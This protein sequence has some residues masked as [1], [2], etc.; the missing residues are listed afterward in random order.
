MAS[1]TNR[2]RAVVGRRRFLQFAGASGAVALA[3]CADLIQSDNGDGGGGG[4]S[5]RHV[6]NTNTVPKDIQWNTSNPSNRAQISN[7]ALFDPFVRY[8]FATSEFTPYAISDW[9][10]GGDTFEMTVRDG[11]TWSNGDDVTS[12][13]V[14]TQLRIGMKTGATYA[15]YTNAIETPDE[16][17]VSLQF[18]SKINQKIVEF[19]ILAER[20]VHQKESEFG[21][22]LE[23]INENEDEGLKQLQEFAY[24]EPIASGPFEYDSADQQQLL[25]TLRE[26]HPDSGK[27]NFGEYVFKYHDGNQAIHQALKNNDIDS[28]FTVFTPTETVNSLPDNIKQ[29]QTPSNWGYGLVPNHNHKHLGDRAVRKAIQFVIN[30]KQVVGNVSPD[31]K[32]VPPYPMGISSGGQE[33]WLGDAIENFESYGPD[34]SQTKKAA[35]VLKDA[36]YTKQNGAWTDSKGNTV[37]LPI[38]EPSGWTDWNTAT[39]TIVDQLNSFGFKASADPRKYGTLSSTVWPN[40][41]FALATG[42]WLDGAPQGAYPYFSLH[43]QL[44]KNFRGFT[45]NYAAADKTRGGKRADVTVPA[46]TGSGTTTVNPA[47]RLN[48]LAAG[49]DEATTKKITTDLAWV[50]NQDLPMIPVMEKV[51]QTFLTDGNE[52][53]IPA[54]DADV[55][56]V[57]FANTWLPRMGEIEYTGE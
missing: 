55:A 15:D 27:I 30:R 47:K 50:T 22:Y 53:K 3:G 56:Q 45:Y 24:Q 20:E 18:D 34:S 36:G 40:G 5:G 48:E 26:A 28:V 57:R 31:S 11:L 54:P 1:S 21:K 2:D 37:K 4:K 14:A 25:L 10:Y 17:T 32:Q 12:A 49:A 42:G 52:W 23:K 7:R 9:S 43:H 16:K 13:D 29:V 46:Q 41:D 39:Q 44:V 33:Q 6:S 8:N 35:T 19:Q 38:I 51:E